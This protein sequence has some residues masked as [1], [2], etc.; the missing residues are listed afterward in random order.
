MSDSDAVRQQG[1]TP[2]SHAPGVRRSWLGAFAARTRRRF[3]ETWLWFPLFALVLLAV[4]WGSVIHV[5]VVE[6]TAATSAAI[7]SSRELADTYEAQVVRNLVS[8]DQTLKSVAYAYAVRGDAALAELQNKDMLP[9]AIVFKVTITNRNGDVTASTRH[10]PPENLANEPYFV[11]QALGSGDSLYID[12]VS[13]DP[14]SGAPEMIFSRRLSDAAG[15]FAGIAM[16]SMD[17]SYFTSSYD[18]PRM[19]RQGFLGLLGSDGAMRVQQTGDDVSWGAALPAGFATSHST[20]TL[21]VQPWDHGVERFTNVRVLHGFPLAAIVGLSRDEQLAHY[22]HDRLVY[23]VETAAGSALLVLLTT[24]LSLKSWQ[25]AKSRAR[26]RQIQQTYFVASEASLDAFFVWERVPAEAARGT[27]AAQTE[28]V[29]RDVSRRGIEMAGQARTQLLGASLDAV[30]ADTDDYHTAREFASVFDTGE[31]EEREWQHVRPGGSQVWLHRQVVRVDNGVVAI[32]RDI[33]ARKLADVRRIE[34]NRVLEMIATSTPLDQV[35]TSLMHLLESQIRDCA[36]AVLLRDDDGLHIRVG[37]APSL[38]ASFGRVANGSLIGPEAGPSGLAIYTHQPVFI[39]DL[40]NDE[41]FGDAVLEAQ[42]TGFTQCRSMPILSHDGN[43]LGAL[44]IFAREDRDPDGVEAQMVAMAIRIAGIAIE[45]TQAEERIRHMAN[46]DAL[47]GLPNRTLLADRLSQVLLHA[48]RYERGVTVVFVD[49]DNFKLINDSLGHRA[50]DDLLKTIAARMVSCVRSTDTVVRLGGDEFVLVLFDDSHEEAAVKATVERLR[51]AI[52][53]PVEL[54]GQKYQV[55]CSMGL[56]NYPADGEDTETLLMNADAAMYR[57]KE[58]GR[59]NYQFYTSEMNIKVHERLRRQEELREALAKGEFR[60]VYQPQVDARTGVIFGVE[61]LLR[62][63]HPTEGTIAP[64]DFIPLAE[65]TGLIVPIG[66]WVLQTACAQNR[67]W[68]D[69]GLPPV[70][71]SVNVSARQFLHKGWIASV[72][73]A[74]ARTGLDPRYLELE[75]TESLIMQ[76]LESSIETMKRLQE[77]GVRLSIDDFG[78]GYSSLSALKHFPIVRL[79]IDKS[80]VRELPHGEDDKAIAMAVI[81]LGQRLNLNVIAEGVETQAQVD[82]LRDNNCHEIQG[83]HYS[84]PVAP[85]HIEAML[86]DL[87]RDAEAAV[88]AV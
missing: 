42:L 32:V 53:E 45:R 9:S 36:C 30:F 84:R 16:L 5:V 55:T 21:A 87:P 25:L 38:P 67:R 27:R 74:L 17:P 58:L 63:D 64:A 73:D 86:R 57:A 68:Q 26:A 61:A 50:G 13:A 62:W 4:A 39:A 85:A 56:A 72:G 10:T 44:T 11:A 78:T 77:M 43:A 40:P 28:F 59:N 75:L 66:E 37:A 29:L 48:Q 46:H 41:R 1:D 83:Y 65:D 22:R 20:E 80:F 3:G 70:T 23:V 52:L 60:V 24:I 82:F 19:G 31:V 2:A 15:R 54:A 79:K 6:H 7:E 34:Q 69:A 14:E 47:T 18:Q 76:D 35:L 51:N 71:V 33:T 88:E 12:R 49:L 8:I 81:S